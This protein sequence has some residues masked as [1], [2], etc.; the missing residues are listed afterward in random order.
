L[1]FSQVT[2][3]TMNIFF[4]SAAIDRFGFSITYPI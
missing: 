1:A 4:S 2:T 3:T